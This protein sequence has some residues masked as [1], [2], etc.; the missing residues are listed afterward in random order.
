MTCSFPS[1]YQTEEK[2]GLTAAQVFTSVRAGVSLISVR[3]EIKTLS[4][5]SLL[6]KPLT[7]SGSGSKYPSFL[8]VFDNY[9]VEVA[10]ADS[11][12]DCAARGNA[13]FQYE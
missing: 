2:R 9:A 7:A 13:N 6:S 4:L 10:R 1:L 12:E 5:P 3:G 8:L 11:L